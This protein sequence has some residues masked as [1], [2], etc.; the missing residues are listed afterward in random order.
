M[1]EENFNLSSRHILVLLVQI[2]ANIYVFKFFLHLENDVNSLTITG[3][4][5]LISSDNTDTVASI[6]T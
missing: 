3:L 5:T 2:S 6:F 4:K 1:K